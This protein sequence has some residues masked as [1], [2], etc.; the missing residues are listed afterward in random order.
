VVNPTF[1]NSKP[2]FSSRLAAGPV[3]L[4]TETYI[5]WALEEHL[6]DISTYV[7]VSEQEAQTSATELYSTIYKGT[8]ESR[9]CSSLTKEATAYICHWTLKN[10]SNPFGHYLMIK[11]TSPKE[12]P[13]LSAPIVQASS[14][15]MEN[16]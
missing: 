2:T 16:G 12:E 5:P 3:G 9:M 8:Q 10:H 1:L 7:Q 13:I 15:S 6:T 14:I 4:D 11:T